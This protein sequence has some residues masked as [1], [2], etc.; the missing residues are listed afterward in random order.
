MLGKIGKSKLIST[1]SA[2]AMLLALATFA[3]ASEGEITVSGNVTVNGQTAVSNSTFVSGSSVVT[4][5]G[6]SA[7]INLGANGK[8]ELLQNSEVSLSFTDSNITTVLKSGAVRVLNAKGIGSVVTTNSA[9]VVADASQDNSYFV[10]VACGVTMVE[11]MSGLVSLKTADATKQVAAGTDAASGSLPQT[12]C[13]QCMRPGGEACLPVAGG[14]GGGTI[15]AILAAA[16]AAAVA[17]IF[18]AGDNEVTTSG[19]TTVVSPSK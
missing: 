17:A 10:N 3:V 1:V 4:G 11:T 13:K 9:T 12:G 16:G 15:A 14:I 2:F 7:T 6:S 18:L 5:E 19:S 8:I